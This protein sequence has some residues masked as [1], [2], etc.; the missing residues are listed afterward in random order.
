MKEKDITAK[1]RSLRAQLDR[2]LERFRGDTIIEGDG[3]L[4]LVEEVRIAITK[5]FFDDLNQFWNKKEFSSC[6]TMSNC[7]SNVKKTHCQKQHPQHFQKE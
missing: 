7:Q 1:A 4:A 6:N 2:L 3:A 5:E